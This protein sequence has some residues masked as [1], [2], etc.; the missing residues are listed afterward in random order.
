MIYSLA[1][2][3]HNCLKVIFPQFLTKLKCFEVQVYCLLG[4]S[5]LE[6]KAILVHLDKNSPPDR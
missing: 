3:L 5:K 1:F 4:K 2:L 6:G